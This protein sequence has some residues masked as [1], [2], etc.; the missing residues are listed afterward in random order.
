MKP[1]AW[2][3]SII[4]QRAVAVGQV[5]DLVEL[6]DRAVHREHAVGDDQLVARAGR[7]RLQLRFEV[8]HVVV[9]VAK[10]RGLAQADAVD[11]RRVVQRVGDDRVLLAEQRLEQA[12]VGVERGRVEDRVFRAEEGRQSLLER[13]VHGLACRR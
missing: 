10:A 2:H 1:D 9:L 5:A 3:S 13:L 4:T 6:G 12:A 11:D 8:G 7:S